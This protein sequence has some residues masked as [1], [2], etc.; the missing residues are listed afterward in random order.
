MVK[1]EPLHVQEWRECQELFEKARDCWRT[2]DNVGAEEPWRDLY[3]RAEDPLVWE[4]RLMLPPKWNYEAEDIVAAAFI[5]LWRMVK[6]GKEVRNV[7]PLL[8]RI[9]SNKV[10]DF[11]RHK[12][13]V[14]SESADAYP[15]F[16]ET[17]SDVD[18]QTSAIDDVERTVSRR[19]EINNVLDAL[20]PL[21]R[22]ILVGRYIR[23]CSIEETARVLNVT[24]DVVKKGQKRAL[25]Q[26]LENMQKRGINYDNL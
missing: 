10:V 25:T 3:D 20:V 12:A 14:H 2:G 17:N 13:N 4:A 21:E 22:G 26:A 19:Q 24:I 23:D 15:D 1:E 9:V 6:T 5:E 7:R 8:K 18:R 16:W 11:L